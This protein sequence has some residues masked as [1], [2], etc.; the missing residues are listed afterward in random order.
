MSQD[1]LVHHAVAGSSS[2]PTNQPTNLGLNTLLIH[3]LM[4]YGLQ[5]NSEKDNLIPA[6]M[7]VQVGQV[8]PP[9]TWYTSGYYV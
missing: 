7:D 6:L 3:G 1:L 5:R 8:I 9:P 4:V 2:Q